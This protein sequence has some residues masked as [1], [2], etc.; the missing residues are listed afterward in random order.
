M[1]IA[2]GCHDGQFQ[3]SLLVYTRVTNY[4]IANFQ[5]TMKISTFG[6]VYL[7]IVGSCYIQCGRCQKCQPNHLFDCRETMSLVP[8]IS[9]SALQ[10]EGMKTTP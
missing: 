8:M 10:K 6:E 7:S 1:T 5:S 3:F 9:S 2:Q 4:Q